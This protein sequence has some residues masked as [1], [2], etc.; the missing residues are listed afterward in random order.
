MHWSRAVLHLTGGNAASAVGC[1]T[2]KF[3]EGYLCLG[4]TRIIKHELVVQSV[5]CETTR[6]Y[7]TVPCLLLDFVDI[8]IFKGAYQSFRILRH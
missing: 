2:Y 4:F 5:T 3:C 1:K 8:C 7:L 6:S